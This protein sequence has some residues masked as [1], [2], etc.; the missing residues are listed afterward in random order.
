[1]TASSTP[2]LV[3]CFDN[4]LVLLAEPLPWLSSV[5]FDIAITAGAAFDPED[6]QGLASLTTDIVLRGAGP[7]DARAFLEDLEN[8]GVVWSE[9]VGH[10]FIHLSAAMRPKHLRDALAIFSDVLRKP[11][12]PQEDLESARQGL[13]QTIQA[14]EDDPEHQLNKALRYRFLPYPWSR[15]PHGVIDHVAAISWQEVAEFVER[16]FQPSGVV[17]GVAGR[18][19]WD[20][21][22]TWVGELLGDWKGSPPPAPET[23]WPTERQ[24]HVPFDSQQTHIGVAYRS[25]PYED[26]HYFL[27][28]AAAGM[29]GSGSSSRLFMEL[30][31]RR[32]LC[33]AVGANYVVIRGFGGVICYVGTTSERAEESLE[34]LLE[35]LQNLGEG[36]TKDELDRAKAQLKSGIVFLQESSAARAHTLT[37]DWSLL[38]R[39][40]SMQEIKEAVDSL[41]TEE[42]NQF[43]RDNP[44]R[45]FTVVTVGPRPVVVPSELLQ[46]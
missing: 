12:L 22:V 10:R 18:F 31:E 27:A 33:Y 2:C 4:G 7:R 42:V 6:R 44:P 37:Q 43:L 3:H 46:P 8:L 9:S 24:A 39:V 5:G 45:D 14:E 21:L 28:R 26:D 1:M 32:G 41:S 15:S 38:G 30:R 11:R 23:R 20:E 17:I 16:H 13:I 29:L 36:V 35:Q 25:I 34:V 19:N 40:R